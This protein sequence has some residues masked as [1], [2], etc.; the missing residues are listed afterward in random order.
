MAQGK[1]QPLEFRSSPMT[2][3]VSRNRRPRAVSIDLAEVA[4]FAAMAEQWWDP[5]GAARMLHRLN[6]VRLGY[7]RDRV[8]ERFGRD[9]LRPRPLEDLDLL[10]L[11]CGGGLVAEPMARLGARVVAIDAAQENIAIAARHASEMGLAIDYRCTSAEELAA[12]KARFDIVLALEIVEH[13][14]DLTA[15]LDASAALVKP[16]GLMVVSTLNRTVKA[17]ALAVIGAE[18]LLR[19]V[20]TGTHDWRKFVRPH[21]LARGLRRSGMNLSDLTGVAYDPLRD[22]WHVAR[23]IDV[24]YMALALK[25]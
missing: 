2:A 1:R 6:P 18:Y 14:A 24:N 25:D 13:V 21:E 16:G 19:W 4:R 23:D 22:H 5:N 15:F 17:Y 12:T 20:P 8:A 11:G 7:I 10:D 3:K 9:P